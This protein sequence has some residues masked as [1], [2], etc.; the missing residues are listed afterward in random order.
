MRDE[1]RK[2]K[3]RWAVYTLACLACLGACRTSPAPRGLLIFSK[4]AGY[5]HDSIPQ[6]VALFQQ[7]A[8]QLGLEPHATEDAAVFSPQRLAPFA[9]VVFLNTTG[10]VLDDD[11]QEAMR[12]WMTR[13]GAGFLGVHAAADTEFDWPW[14][15][16]LVGA[17]FHSHPPVQPAE[18]IVA[19]RSH[20]ST[21]HLPA[22]WLRTDEWYDF[23]ACPGPDARVLLLLDETTY[24]GATTVASGRCATHPAAW[25]RELEGPGDRRVR[26]FYT[27]GG[28]TREA[29]AEPAFIEHLRGGLRWT[30]RRGEE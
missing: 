2:T 3:W 6:G 10:D 18:L 27:A 15:Q 24:T 19:D 25:C 12:A 7:L 17:R 4:T 23:H 26:A 1:S 11:Q 13:S 21:T 28:H 5:R 20:P 8:T 22:R 14:Y 30:L 9:A 16:S 29:Y